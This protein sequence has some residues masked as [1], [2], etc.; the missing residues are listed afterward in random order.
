MS[1]P[2][3]KDG[4]EA[5]GSAVNN[6]I[7]VSRDGGASFEPM[8]GESRVRKPGQVCHPPQLSVLSH[9]DKS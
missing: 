7:Y 1:S 6:H 3:L 9:W 5:S 8:L 4:A 2:P